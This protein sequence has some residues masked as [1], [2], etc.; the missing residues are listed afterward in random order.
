MSALPW[1]FDDGGRAGAGFATAN[2]AGDCVC[3]AIA[4]ATDLPYSRIYNLLADQAAAHGGRRS[5][6]DGVKRKVYD[7]VLS[8]LGWEWMPTMAIGSGCTVHLAEGELPAGRLICRLSKHIVAVVNGIVH[9]TD[10]PGREGTRCVYGYW[11]PG[12]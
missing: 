7:A 12:S 4:I 2:D 1:V 3:R 10:D 11:R 9:D 5:A 6:R 8:E